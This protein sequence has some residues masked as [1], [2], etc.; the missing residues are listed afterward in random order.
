MSNLLK[1]IKEYFNT[2]N[3]KDYTFY[4]D[5][6]PAEWCSLNSNIDKHCVVWDIPSDNNERAWYG[7]NV[8]EIVAI[9]RTPTT[10]EIIK[11]NG[12]EYTFTA[13]LK[14]KEEK[15]KDI[16]LKAKNAL[17]ARNISHALGYLEELE[18]LMNE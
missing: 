15:A 16:I 3:H 14:S 1:H 4:V 13:K 8:N 2:F 9:R 10:M 7:V 18:A 11:T 6:N 5:G 12:K 17:F